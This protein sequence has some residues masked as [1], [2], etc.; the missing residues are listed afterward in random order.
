M[1]KST[2]KNFCLLALL[3][4]T[5][6]FISSC[7]FQLRGTGNNRY[8]IPYKTF[9]I[10][11]PENSDVKIWLE[12]Y[13]RATNVANSGNDG[14]NQPQTTLLQDFD[15]AENKKLPAEQQIFVD[16]IFQQIADSRQKYILSLTS[17]GRVREYRL[18]LHYQFRIINSNGDEVIPLNTI[19]LTRDISYDDNSLL[20]KDLEEN[21]L[22][23]D[24]T[25]D[26]VNQIMFRLTAM[27]PKIRTQREE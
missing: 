10:Q 24:L 3:L 7:G 19:S 12:R 5:A 6:I 21:I 8:A 4:V 17:S 20:A 15:F 23:K 26:L 22:W 2:N 11:L 18:Q 13:I 1:Q 14:E 25:N 9:F 27:Q 16:G